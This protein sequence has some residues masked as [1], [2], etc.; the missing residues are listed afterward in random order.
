M[1]ASEKLSSYRRKRDFAKTAEPTGEALIVTASRRRFVIQKHAATRL[2]YDLRLE[3]DGVFKSWAV[4]RGP[5]LDPA[6]KR[7]AVEVEDHPLD[8]GDFE[9]TIP[10]GQ[11]GGGTVQLWDRGYWEPEGDRTPEEALASGDFKFVLDGERLHGGWVLVRMKWDRKSGKHTNWLLIKHRDEFARYG[12]GEVLSEDRS[13]ASGRS[14]ATIAAGK[15]RSPKPFMLAAKNGAKP[16]AVWN[17]NRGVAADARRRVQLPSNSIKG[18]PTS[19]QRRLAALPD[20]IAPQLCQSVSRPPNGTGWLHEIKFDGYRIQLRIQDGKVNLKTRKGLDWTAKFR[21]IAAGAASLADA[22]IDGEIVALDEHGAPDFAA[23]QAALSEQNTRDL[24]FYGFDLLFDGAGDLRALAVAERKRRLETLLSARKA[25]EDV[26]VRFVEHFETG[27][28][29]VLRSACKLS[30]EGIVSKRADAPYQSGRTDSWRKAKCRAGHEVVIGGWSTTE[31]DFRSLLV[32]VNRGD[33]FV[34]IG[35]VGTGYSESKVKQLLPRLKP[36]EV[37]TSP[38]TGRGAPRKEAGVHWVK[39]ELVAEIEFAG[40]T[41][42]GMVRQAAFKGLREDKP[43]AEV[44]TETPAP[45]ETASV[46]NPASARARKAMPSTEKPVVMGV[47]IS[48]P[49]KPL[50]P[51]AGDG[52]PV[53]KLDLARYFEAVGPWIMRHIKGRPCSIIRVPDGIGGE[54]F[55]QRHAMLGMSNLLEL[56]TVFGDRK[57]YLQIDRLEG[58]AAVAQVAAL[59][60]HP[61]NCQPQQPEIPGRLVFDLDPGPDVPFSAVVVAAKEMR[62]RLDALGLVSFCKTTGGKGLHVVTPLALAKKSALTWP[63]AKSFAREVCLQLAREYPDRY[64]LNMAK[65]LRGG[66]IF[67]DYLRNDRMA[68]AV[69]PLSPRARPGAAVSMPLTWAQLKPD[70]DP[71]RFTVRSVPALLRKTKAWADY[72]DGERALGDAIKRLGEGTRAA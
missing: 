3:L 14:M 40:W 18:I 21:A 36:M 27:G 22:I 60:L 70:L 26:R 10:K 16:D 69:A 13:I 43:A 54:Q 6:D 41:G 12:D 52:E 71:K 30:L 47:L 20:F 51:D 17:S 57:P 11:Y 66:R 5:S 45:A 44:E 31:G 8:Y 4:A 7:L 65:R 72:C 68:T 25:G 15:G 38:F 2:H 53:T 19:P 37:A 58:L 9:G 32:G 61:W 63:D 62:E 48:K 46:T 64:I 55:F 1:A 23:L 42:D 33:H 39:P 29:A 59:E 50:W 35:R 34:Y 56:V 67:L 49:E 24:V 28:D